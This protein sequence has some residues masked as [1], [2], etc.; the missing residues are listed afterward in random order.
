MSCEYS[1]NYKFNRNAITDKSQILRDRRGEYVFQQNWYPSELLTPCGLTDE[2]RNDFKIMKEI[3]K[4]TKKYPADRMQLNSNKIGELNGFDSSKKKTKDK[5][6]DFADE[7]DLN[8]DEGSNSQGALLFTPPTIFFGGKDNKLN[9][10]LDRS[11]FNMKKKI[12]DEKRSMGKWALVYDHS[13][14]DFVEECVDMLQSASGTYG[15]KI[16]EPSPIFKIDGRNVR[17]DQLLKEIL[18]ENKS[19]KVVFFFVHQRNNFYNSV[20]Q[21]FTEK[22]ILTQFFVNFNPKR[23][24]NLSVYSK[25][26]LQMMAKQ[27]KVLWR[28]QRGLS[29]NKKDLAMMIGIDLI[30]Y[31]GGHLISATCT[32]DKNF[33]KFYNECGYVKASTKQN[34]KDFNSTCISNLV[35]KCVSKFTKKNEKFPKNVIIYRGG[36]AT[37]DTCTTTWPSK[38]PK[39]GPSSTL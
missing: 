9:V 10:K 1:K 7:L 34:T 17:A 16:G 4:E 3:A 33:T 29:S 32:M 27:G 28:V 39:F 36:T 11:N 26:L 31:R 38:P 37:R 21:H 5:F 30:N 6:L 22:K 19:V 35:K 13:K 20:K 12:F 8:I 25:L 24:P 23:K 2:M 18:E 15:V 14:S